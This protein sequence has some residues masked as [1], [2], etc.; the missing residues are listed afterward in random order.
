G[1]EV[2]VEWRGKAAE[3]GDVGD[4]RLL[5]QRGNDDPALNLGE[6]A[7][8][9]GIGFERVIVDLPGGRRPRVEARRNAGRQGGVLDALIDAQPRP[10]ILY[11]VAEHDGDQ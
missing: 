10:I 4:A 8:P 3:V 11:A 2:R 5:F 9:L 1:M 6:L 7:L